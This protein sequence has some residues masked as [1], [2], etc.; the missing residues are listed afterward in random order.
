MFQLPKK[1]YAALEALLLIAYGGSATPISSKTLAEHLK[2]SPRY[3]EQALQK[4]VKH[5]ILHSG[6]GPKGG[7][8]LG[9]ERR[10]ITLREVLKLLSQEED[11]KIQSRLGKKVLAPLLDLAS[12]GASK[13]F[14]ELTLADLCASAEDANIPKNFRE[15]VDFTI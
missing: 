5:G 6:R 4:L 8:T 10:R 11:A 13:T 2:L 7:Y 15:T 9:R 14:T 3:L 1:S 12:A